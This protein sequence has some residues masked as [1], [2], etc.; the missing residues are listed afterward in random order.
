M[1][2][3]LAG[4]QRDELDLSPSLQCAVEPSLCSALPLCGCPRL[5]LDVLEV[6]FRVVA[7]GFLVV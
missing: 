2:S 7:V 3:F 5:V 4:G 6:D 1:H